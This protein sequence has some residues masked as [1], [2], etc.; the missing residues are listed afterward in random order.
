MSLYQKSWLY[1]G[2][3]L[4]V[5]ITSTFWLSYLTRIYGVPGQVVG[6]II[7]LAHGLPALFWFKCR[8]CG[9]SIFSRRKTISLFRT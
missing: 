8:M 7:W 4:F 3:M 5:F 1:V 2:W 6:S 9:V